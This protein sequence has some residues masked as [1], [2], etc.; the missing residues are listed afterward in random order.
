MANNFLTIFEALNI[1]QGFFV[2][3]FFLCKFDEIC[4]VFDANERFHT[5]MSIVSV[6]L[7]RTKNSIRSSRTSVAKN[8]KRRK[9][10]EKQQ[11]DL[12]IEI[13][14]NRVRN[15][16]KYHAIIAII[17]IHLIYRNV[18]IVYTPL[19]TFIPQTQH[20][21]HE[22]HINLEFKGSQFLK[23]NNELWIVYHLQ[24]ER[25]WMRLMLNVELVTSQVLLNNDEYLMV[26]NKF[27]YYEIFQ[28]ACA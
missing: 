6:S 16:S 3:I 23:S 21:K 9:I 5:F 17:I 14:S 10:N 22:T 2:I 26:F 1:E 13:N 25:S 28:N 7:Y 24:T 15:S 11:W 27:Q 19:S 20:M 8:N 18:F 4:I 12:F